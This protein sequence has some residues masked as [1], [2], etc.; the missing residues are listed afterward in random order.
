MGEFDAL[1]I[2]GEEHGVVAD[3]IAAAERVHA[4]FARLARADVA[5]AA[6][7]D[8]VLIGGAGFLVEDFQE[9]ARGAGRRV[10]LVFVVH[11]GD[12]DVEAVLGEDAR[13]VAGEPEQRVHA[14]RVVR[15]RKRSAWSWRPRG[16]RRVPHRC[17]RWCR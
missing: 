16:S 1:A 17:G 15:R 12:L 4:D 5:E 3:D 7:G 9:A 10:D 2:G 8:V 13:G 11:L 6:V 14:D